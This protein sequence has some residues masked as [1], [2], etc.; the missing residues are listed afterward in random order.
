M[1]QNL[2][3]RNFL[4]QNFGKESNPPNHQHKTTSNLDPGDSE[5]WDKIGIVG[6]NGKGK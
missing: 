2:F 5:S 3:P 6:G 1:I 4:P